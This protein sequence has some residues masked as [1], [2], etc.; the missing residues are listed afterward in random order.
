MFEDQKTHFMAFTNKNVPYPDL[1][2]EKMF[3]MQKKIVRIIHGARPR[4]HT[5]PLFEGA[6]ILTI[7]QINTLLERWYLM[8]IIQ[9][10]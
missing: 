7:Y 9:I 3:L 8:Y 4:T 2:L 10:L 6:K 1:H 5:E